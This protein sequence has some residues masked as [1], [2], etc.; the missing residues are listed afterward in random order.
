MSFDESKHPRVAKGQKGGGQFAPLG[1]DGGHDVR[2]RQLLEQTSGSL[3][4][5]VDALEST[6][7][8]LLEQVGEHSR[9]NTYLKKLENGL[10][11]HRVKAAALPK[12]KRLTDERV[13]T[14]RAKEMARAMAGAEQLAK[15]YDLSDSER[16]RLAKDMYEAPGLDLRDWKALLKNGHKGYVKMS[17]DDFLGLDAVLC[18]ADGEVEATAD[19]LEFWKEMAHE[20]VAVKGN[21][22][23]NITRALLDHMH[24]TFAEMSAVGI[25]VPVPIEHTKDP[26]KRRGTVKETRRKKNKKGK[27]A[28]YGRVRFRDA[29]AAKLAKLSNVSIFVPKFREDGKGGGWRN[30][31]EHLAITDYP[32]I[33]GLEPF[34]PVVLSFAELAWDESEH[35]REEAGSAKGGQFASAHEAVKRDPSDENVGRAAMLAKT[36]AELKQ[37][38]ET[39]AGAKKAGPLHTTLADA[40]YSKGQRLP[41]GWDLYTHPAGHSAFASPDNEDWSHTEHRGVEGAYGEQKNGTGAAALAKH[42]AKV[43]GRKPVDRGARLFAAKV[44]I[45]KENREAALEKRFKDLSGV[46]NATLRKAA[47]SDS[48]HPVERTMARAE[49]K[50]RMKSKNT[51]LS[52]AFTTKDKG[53]EPDADDAGAAPEPTLRDLATMLGV[54]PAVTDEKQLLGLMKQAL[55]AKLQPPAQPQAPPQQPPMPGAGF[56]APPPRPGYRPGMP[57]M[58]YSHDEDGEPVALSGALL[59]TVRSARK[60]VVEDLFRQGYLTVPGKKRLED[61]FLSDDALKFSHVGDDGFND[62]VE[63]ARANGVR[64]P[65]KGA[66]RSGPQTLPDG[67]V[68]L[69]QA[70]DPKNN[71]IMADAQRRADAAAARQ[72]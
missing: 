36:S 8:D 48:P 52:M 6:H 13:A 62:A 60:A 7:D 64:V 67:V 41:S 51:E 10:T 72:N 32:V 65:M 12:L 70:L 25:E 58:Q 4:E 20:G 31:L 56:P 34:E 28:I 53:G 11:G 39:V 16:D 22:R 42:L 26:E 19:P 30:P 50:K 61:R 71:P 69:S 37:L 24:Q 47:V 23:V 66:G 5:K 68:A 14:Y 17:Q 44:A 9:K 45:D 3:Q 18:L 43:A 33:A 59:D 54:D 29:E 57:P 49:L 55:A 1:G 63:D 21:T 2:A 27:E 35:P 46:S 40:G 15:K 38:H